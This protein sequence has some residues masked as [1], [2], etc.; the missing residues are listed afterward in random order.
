MFLKVTPKSEKKQSFIDKIIA[1]LKMYYKNLILVIEYKILL[2]I[3][4]TNTHLSA[5]ET[6]NSIV[7][8]AVPIG[9]HPCSN[10][11]FHAAIHPHLYSNWSTSTSM[12]Q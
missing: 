8:R 7:V 3:L 6:N 5:N 4:L 12:Q 9:S 1:K 11:H 10:I 2:N